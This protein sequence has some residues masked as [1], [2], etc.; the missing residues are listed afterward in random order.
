[1]FLFLSEDAPYMAGI[2]ETEGLSF[3]PRWAV[4]VWNTCGTNFYGPIND[5]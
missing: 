5:L 1:M 4:H 2:T 3:G